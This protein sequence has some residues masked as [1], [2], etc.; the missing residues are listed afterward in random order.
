[1]HG[2]KL[3]I[4]LKNLGFGDRPTEGGEHN[5]YIL[6]F[7]VRK[8]NSKI[9]TEVWVRYAAC[10]KVISLS[11]DEETTTRDKLGFISAPPRY[12]DGD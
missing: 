7:D 2:K 11:P 9:T 4:N 3:S 1:M 10:W 8:E 5:Q 6:H 12:C